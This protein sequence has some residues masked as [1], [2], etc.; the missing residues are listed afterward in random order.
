[1]VDK[2][3]TEELETLGNVVINTFSSFI[4]TFDKEQSRLRT[5]TEKNLTE[6]RQA[7]IDTFSKPIDETQLYSKYLELTEY[8]DNSS[9][10]LRDFSSDLGD[11]RDAFIRTMESISKSDSE[12]M[13][14]ERALRQAGIPVQRE[15]IDN[16]FKLRVLTQEEIQQR[17]EDMRIANTLIEE[18]RSELDELKNIHTETGKLSDEQQ[19]RIISL[20][21]N[22]DELD[23]GIE[24]I[25]SMGI[26]EVVEV[27]ND[28]VESVITSKESIEKVPD[29]FGFLFNNLKKA[30]ES[31]SKAGSVVKE[32]YN[33]F[34]D[35]FLPGP[36]KTAFGAFF[37]SINQG[38]ESIADLFKPITGL[39]KTIV[40]LPGKIS[41]I[42]EKDGPF[43]KALG[44][45]KKALLAVS[46]FMT[47][48]LLPTLLP[49]LGPIL[50]VG[51]AMAGL[52]IAIKKIID[53]LGSK[54]SLPYDEQIDVRTKENIEKL[55]NT[56]IDKPEVMEQ[57][58]EEIAIEQTDNAMTSGLS[59]GTLG[60]VESTFSTDAEGDVIR[61]T[62]SG[63]KFVEEMKGEK[64]LLETDVKVSKEDVMKYGDIRDKLA[65]KFGTNTLDYKTMMNVPELQK[66]YADQLKEL[67][68]ERRIMEEEKATKNNML[69]QQNIQTNSDL[70]KIDNTT[71]NGAN[72]NDPANE[73]N[74]VGN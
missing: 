49:L 9:E 71:V 51:G 26:E 20:S 17:Q 58:A 56:T 59:A 54:D 73:I 41:S 24:K 35:T 6:Q 38:V 7:L 68:E 67:N 10:S 44:R 39:Y 28:I 48:T 45:F 23:S 22:I 57:K 8:I 2:A 72:A 55:E 15:L 52:Y 21:N 63:M 31:V 33:K 70:T 11:G 62:P 64:D 53:F 14:K 1:M 47:G 61:T 19:E 50:L 12:I 66:K 27:K 40:S 74:A 13:V 18:K 34:A 43:Q 60:N 69:N 16:Q 30:G 36:I 25:K 29:M 42:F 32:N 5:I 65:S 4:T 3:M 37:E 46:V